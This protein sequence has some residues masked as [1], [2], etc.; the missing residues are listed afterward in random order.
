MT[1]I[2][3]GIMVALMVLSFVP[4]YFTRNLTYQPTFLSDY[5]HSVGINAA[6]FLV[7]TGLYFLGFLHSSFI[8]FKTR[9]NISGSEYTNGRQP[10][11]TSSSENN[12][13]E[14]EIEQ[15]LPGPLVPPKEFTRSSDEETVTAGGMP[16][17]ELQQGQYVLPTTSTLEV[18]VTHSN[19]VL[20]HGLGLTCMEERPM[21]ATS[22]KQA[23]EMSAD[24]KV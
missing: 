19:L 8:L 3:D 22:S 21:T 9:N 17:L 5:G 1:V 7:A 14:N 24:N 23:V 4:V 10:I 12:T 13:N 20:P 2:I 6:M 18:P 16:S 15:K 11:W